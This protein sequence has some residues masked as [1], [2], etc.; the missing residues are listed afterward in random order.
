MAAAKKKFCCEKIFFAAKK[1]P[2]HRTQC[3]VL[4]AAGWAL[5]RGVRRRKEMEMVVGRRRRRRRGRR[6]RQRER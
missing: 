3:P 5:L 1:F 4:C 2:V 6:A